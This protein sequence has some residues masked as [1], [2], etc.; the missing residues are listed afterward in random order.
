MSG[1]RALVARLLRG[2]LVSGVLGVSMGVTHAP[3]EAASRRVLGALKPAAVV[4]T[5]VVDVDSKSGLASRVFVQ[6]LDGRVAGKLKTEDSL[7][8]AASFGLAPGR[9][10]ITAT[11]GPEYTVDQREVT[12]GAGD[13]TVE[14]ALRRVVDAGRW[15]SC[16]LHVHSS[17]SFDSHVSPE[18]R[19]RALWAAGVAFGAPTEHDAVGSYEGTAAMARGLRSVHAMEVTPR[20]P[21]VGHFTV[22]P[23]AGETAPNTS[24]VSP[25]RLLRE[26]RAGSPDALIQINHP[27]LSSGMGYFNVIRFDARRGFKSDPLPPEVDTIEVLNGIVLRQ[28]AQTEQVMHEWAALFEAGHG[29]WATAGSDVHHPAQIPGVPRSYARPATGSDA[30]LIAALRTGHSFATS[31]PFLELSQG[32]RI[33]GD[34]G[35]VSEGKITVHVRLQAAPW[36]DVRHVE[37]WAGGVPVWHRELAERAVRVG[38]PGPDA[39]SER[40]EAVRFDEDVTIAVP[41]GARAVLAVARGARSLKATLPGVDALPVAVTNPLTL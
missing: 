3:A 5:R 39:A 10:R 8:G 34:R 17:T 4:T 33:P 26:L 19:A 11:H 31:G 29:R 27:R 13:A 37:L 35:Q 28:P 14:L 40:S 41:P 15:V 7:D 9:Y 24:H 16:D 30:G 32:D 23:Y 1:V 18:A 21:A 6:K 12:V 20:A 22:L 36:I 2:A 38:P 25:T